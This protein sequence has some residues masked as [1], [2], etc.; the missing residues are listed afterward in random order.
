MIIRE[1]AQINSVGSRILLTGGRAPATLDLARQLAA[2]GHEIFVAESCK[3]HLCQHSRA[4]KRSYLVQEPVSDPQAYLDEIRN[5]IQT[6]QI[7]WLIPM[8]EEL[9]Y[10]SGGL[11]YLGA[12]CHVFVEPLGKL[13]RL[14]SKWEFI[15]RVQKLGLVV[16]GTHLLSSKQEGL[17]FMEAAVNNAKASSKW[18]FKPVFSRFSS[19]VH[20][21]EVTAN[22]WTTTF[23]LGD[24]DLSAATP[25]IAQQFVEGTGFCSYSVAHQGEITAHAVYPVGFTVGRGA[26]IAFEPAQHR[27]I[28]AWVERFVRE[29][30]FTGQIAFDFIVTDE[31]EIYPLECNPRATSGIHLFTPE[32]RLDRAFLVEAD[33]PLPTRIVPRPSRRAMITL[34]MLSFGAANCLKGRSWKKIT[35]WMRFLFSSEDVVFRSRDFQP[36]WQQFRLIHWNW[37]VGV[38]HRISVM[39][40]STMDIEWN[41]G[42][43]F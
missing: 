4:V 10:I 22:G 25:W 38:R 7:E 11:A 15:L 24:E 31:D 20:L 2:N 41:G 18:V 42:E 43:M 29:E 33:Q 21:A 19:K 17:A 12:Y 36:F 28:D 8:C 13:R 40:A 6:E 34:A 27:Q 26:C 39:E 35:A 30:G 23:H 14:H 3:E 37:R 32:D 5:I 16:P 1:Q 9:F